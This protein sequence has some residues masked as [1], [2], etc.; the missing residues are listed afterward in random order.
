[1]KKDDDPATYLAERL[2]GT[3]M[4]LSVSLPHSSHLTVCALATRALERS[5]K[6]NGLPNFKLEGVP[7]IY[8]T[9]R[10]KAA[11]RFCVLPSSLGVATAVQF[12]FF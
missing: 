1:M 4:G 2:W 10:A 6:S 11:E 3:S 12:F 8:T 5:L 9:I 7:P